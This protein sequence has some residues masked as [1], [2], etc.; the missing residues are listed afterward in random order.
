MVLR[1]LNIAVD[2]FSGGGSLA[3]LS[4]HVEKMDKKLLT[5]KA[6][7]QMVFA[8]I[9]RATRKVHSAKEEIRLVLANMRHHPAVGATGRAP[10]RRVTGQTVL[11]LAAGGVPMQPCQHAKPPVDTPCH[12][13]NKA[14]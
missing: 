2:R 7:V 3:H 6:V 8:L 4:L 5:R 14:R 13:R 12:M 10:K 11:C 9:C 1:F